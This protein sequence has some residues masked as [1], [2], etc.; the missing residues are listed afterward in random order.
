MGN[1]TDEE[2]RGVKDI[3]SAWELFFLEVIECERGRDG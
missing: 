2:E 3:R 1:V